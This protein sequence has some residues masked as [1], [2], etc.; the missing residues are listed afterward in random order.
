MPGM[1]T[2]EWKIHLRSDPATV[3]E[4]LT[5]ASGQEKFWAET[6]CEKKGAVHFTFPNGESY[7]SKILYC[8]PDSEF[9]LDYFNSHLKFISAPSKEEGTDLTLINENVATGEYLDV[10]AGWISVLLNL[11]AAVD[12]NCDLRNHDIHKTWDQ[13]YVDN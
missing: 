1:N 2:V 8:K 9:H 3:F 7:I 4:F 13:G 10:S 12:Y 6:A 11:K 5:S